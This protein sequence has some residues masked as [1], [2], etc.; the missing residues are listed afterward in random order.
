MLWLKKLRLYQNK[1][2]LALVGVIFVLVISGGIY[3][4]LNPP[5]YSVT[6]TVEQNT[7]SVNHTHSSVSV[8]SSDLFDEGEKITDPSRY[9]IK[10][11]KEVEINYTPIS[12]GSEL[13]SSKYSSTYSVYVTAEIPT[14]DELVYRKSV[15]DNGYNIMSKSED[16]VSINMEAFQSY[17]E[18]LRQELPQGSLIYLNV[19][20]QTTITSTREP[21]TINSSARVYFSDSRTYI[22]NMESSPV[23]NRQT[24]TIQRP[25][26]AQTVT[27]YDYNLNST[28]LLVIL[29]SAGIFS[30][31]LYLV[32]V[33]L[34]IDK[35]QEELQFEYE[36]DKYSSWITDGQPY[37]D[38]TF[39]DSANIIQVESI[40][41][42]VDI[43][44][45]NSTRVVCTKRSGRFYVYDE[46][47]IYTYTAPSEDI[48]FYIGPDERLPEFGQEDKNSSGD[49]FTSENMD[50]SDEESDKTGE[51][52]EDSDDG[53]VFG[54]KQ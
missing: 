26:P 48:G 54:G 41:G 11:H 43:A 40:K 6:E 35:D 27:I 45:D 34:Y 30:I 42:L 2:T 51:T 47:A 10:N 29:L 19:D 1:Q 16:R 18:R 33:R 39:K 31:L 21:V 4:A 52:G 3:L 14:S 5:T 44:I 25:Q 46:H 53:D 17:R 49:P 36:L 9:F 12:N 24:R 15:E 37:Q 32:Y 28:G 7:Y 13:E 22:V 8:Q 20:K 23:E 50:I 38:P